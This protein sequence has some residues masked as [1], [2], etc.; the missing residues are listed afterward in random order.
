MRRLAVSSCLLVVL[1]MATSASGARTPGGATSARFV[2]RISAVTTSGSIVI[3][4]SGAV[5]NARGLATAQLTSSTGATFG[6]VIA[7]SPHLTTFIHGGVVKNLPDGKTWERDDGAATAPFIDPGLALRL[8]SRGGHKLGT[9]RLGTVSTTKYA[10][11]IS[12]LDATLLAPAASKKL[13]AAGVPA[14]VWL[15]SSGDVRLFHTAVP[16]GSGGTATIDEAFAAFGTPVHVALPPAGAVWDAQVDGAVRAAVASVEA[17]NADNNAGGAHDPDKFGSGYQG[18]TLAYLTKNYDSGIDQGLKIVR[19]TAASYC[20]ELT[21]DG[22][23][24]NKK[25]PSASITSG[26]C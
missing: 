11:H 7:S 4:G 19:A 17:Y 9:V 6:A 2:L 26:H 21:Q 22:I 25:G 10:I 16:F 8:G 12:P 14:V 20:I 23:T 5:D 18:M 13:L 15:D 24:L 1:L 3:D